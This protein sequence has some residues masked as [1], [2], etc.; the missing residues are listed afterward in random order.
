LSLSRRESLN[1]IRNIKIYQVCSYKA[2]RFCQL[3]NML[4]NQQHQIDVIMTA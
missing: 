4:M 1:L 3:M 2:V